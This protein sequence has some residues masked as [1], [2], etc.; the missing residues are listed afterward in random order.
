VA[1]LASINKGVQD[2]L[3]HVL[4]RLGDLLHLGA[5]GWQMLDR[6]GSP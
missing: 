3:L 1:E 4:L 6:L 5:Q 2:V